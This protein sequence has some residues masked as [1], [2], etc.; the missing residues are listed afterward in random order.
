[1]E[2]EKNISY[3]INNSDHI[4]FCDTEHYDRYNRI[5]ENDKT[6]SR[7]D[8]NQNPTINL[9]ENKNECT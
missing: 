3:V 8:E 1:M 2:N 4:I 6:N 5:H 9:K 7:S